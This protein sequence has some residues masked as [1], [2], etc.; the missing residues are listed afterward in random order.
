MQ[1]EMLSHLNRWSNEEKAVYLSTSLKGPAMA[2]LNS[3]SR[4]NLYDY[5]ALVTALGY[6]I[7]ISMYIY[8]GKGM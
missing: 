8:D 4:S 7:V 5:Q 3:L 1:F 2:V 6:V